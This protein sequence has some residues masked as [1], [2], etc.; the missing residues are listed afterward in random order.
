LGP[1]SC[2]TKCYCSPIRLLAKGFRDACYSGLIFKLQTLKQLPHT[3]IDGGKLMVFFCSFVGPFWGCLFL[4]TLTLFYILFLAPS[5]RRGLRP[6][7]KKSKNGA[8]VTASF[9]G[10]R[11]Y[12]KDGRGAPVFSDP[13]PV[14][15]AVSP[16]N[17]TQPTSWPDFFFFTPRQRSWIRDHRVG[18]LRAL[19]SWAVASSS[20]A[21]SSL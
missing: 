10:H 6:G 11:Y 17:P 20:P 21:H 8:D 1:G 7:P 19:V 4:L 5:E 18:P 16:T 14:Y 12:L 3:A 13:L 15:L 9:P 2:V